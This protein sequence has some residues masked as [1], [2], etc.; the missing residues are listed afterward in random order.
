VD[1]NTF[2]I[3]VFVLTDDWLE[4]QKPLRRHG[5]AP[6]LCDSE[7]LTIEIVGEYTLD[8][9]SGGPLRLL[10]DATNR[11]HYGEWFPALCRV[12]R[13]T[14]IRQMAN[15]WAMKNK[16][17]RELLE[18]VG[19]DRR[20]RS[21]T[22]SRGL[23]AC[24]IN[25]KVGLGGARSASFTRGTALCELFLWGSC[26]SF[27]RVSTKE[28]YQRLVLRVPQNFKKVNPHLYQTGS[29][30]RNSTSTLNKPLLVVVTC[31]F[32]CNA[33]WVEDRHK[34]RRTESAQPQTC[35]LKRPTPKLVS[36]NHSNGRSL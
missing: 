16:L 24:L 8:R 26:L 19:F 2:I 27:G 17:W 12:H 10:M 11:R 31:N 36:C 7:V 4:G 33:Y 18:Q 14:F 34:I 13:T 1:L 21:C 15:F 6:E 35:R 3:A 20:C 5:P 30:S 25:S 9:H 23:R 32:L 28:S 22:K 29:Y